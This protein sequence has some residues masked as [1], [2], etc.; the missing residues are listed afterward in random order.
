MLAAGLSCLEVAA[1]LFV[2]VA[3]PDHLSE[4]RL[5]FAQAI[6][7]VA[8]VISPVLAHKALFRGVKSRNKLIDTEWCYLAVAIAVIAL[9]VAFY[10]MPLNEV[11]DQELRDLAE[12]RAAISGQDLNAKIFNVPL[13][14]LVAGSGIFVMMMYLGAQES[15]SYFWFNFIT[16]VRQG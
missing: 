5:N 13:K 4:C 1:N 6:Q 16:Q 2:A 12:D 9:S 11:D 3:G 15:T 14:I 7:G 8:S 10:Y